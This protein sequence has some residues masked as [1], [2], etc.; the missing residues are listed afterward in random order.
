MGH[1]NTIDASNLVFVQFSMKKKK[2]KKSQ[3]AEWA[4]NILF[5][6]NGSYLKHLLTWK[7][8]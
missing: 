3:H 8:Y 1:F 4:R 6:E 5:I 2:I 7:L